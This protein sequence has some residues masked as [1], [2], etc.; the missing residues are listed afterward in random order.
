MRITQ[1]VYSNIEN[2]VWSRR[3][4]TWWILL[5]KGNSW[6]IDGFVFDQN[7]LALNAAVY[8]PNTDFLN[9]VLPVKEAEWYAFI[10]VVHSHPHWIISPSIPDIRASVR[11]LTNGFNN[12]IVEY[13]LPIVQSMPT[14][15]RFEIYPYVVDRL[16]NVRK[17][18]L[19]IV[20]HPPTVEIDLNPFWGWAVSMPTNPFWGGKIPLVVNP[21]WG[22]DIVRAVNPFWKD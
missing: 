18:V 21:F 16:G 10:G 1:E 9:S 8:T 11:N 15:W 2:T 6:L 20:R 7:S 12:H 5:S 14:S 17:Q 19:Q 13:A 22:N 3:A 4:E